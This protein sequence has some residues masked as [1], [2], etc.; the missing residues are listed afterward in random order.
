MILGNAIWISGKANRPGESESL[1]TTNYANGANGNGCERVHLEL[2]AKLQPKRS[3]RSPTLQ[4]NA[5]MACFR[6]WRDDL[7]VVRWSFARGSLAMGSW[8]VYIV[9]GG[10]SPFCSATDA[11]G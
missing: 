6:R 5:T 11:I 8:A 1:S 3:G 10:Q 7:R 9:D 2:L 4:K